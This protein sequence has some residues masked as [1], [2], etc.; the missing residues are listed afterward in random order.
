MNTFAPS[1]VA[2]LL[3]KV[4]VPVAACAVVA[5][6][7]P[8]TPTVI[9]FAAA[10]AGR[11]ERGEPAFGSFN[12]TEASAGQDQRQPA[13]LEGPRGTVIRQILGESVD[14]LGVQEVNPSSP[15]PPAWSTGRTSTST[16]ATGSTRLAATSRS[17]TPTPTTACDPDTAYKCRYKARGASN[18]ERILTTPAQRDEALLQLD[19]V[20]A[21]GRRHRAC[22]LAWA[23]SGR[24]PT[25]TSSCSPPPPQPGPPRGPPGPVGPD[26]P[27]DQADPT[28]LPGRQ[29]RRL[30]HPEVRHHDQ[31][32]AA[33]DEEGGLRRRAQPAATAQ[34]GPA[35]SAP[36]TAST[37]GSTQQP[38]EAQH[39]DLELRGPSRQDRQQHRLH[40]R[41]QLPEGARV[42]AGRQPQRPERR[43]GS[44]PRTTT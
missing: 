11:L 15:S 23:W 43:T 19:A 12:V 21:P 1:R 29:R 40:L 3:T 9:C 37:R 22:F 31:A 39:G 35:A 32:D 26:D 34:P 16:C 17:P 27:Q 36:S 7:M 28:R 8:T 42:Q 2:S 41:E 5:T 25:A 4:L 13:P 6:L 14:V 38:P 20:Q 24:R 10:H 44:S 33:G 30:Q 18:S